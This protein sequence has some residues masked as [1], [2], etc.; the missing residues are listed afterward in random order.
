VQ[1]VEGIAP[2]GGPLDMP[3]LPG[4]DRGLVA[5]MRDLPGHPAGGEL[6]A[7]F[8]RVVPGVEVDPDV[9]GQRAQV[10]EFVQRRGQQRGVVPTRRGQH[11]VQQDAVAVHHATDS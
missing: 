5:F 9:I 4:L 11:A 1:L 8:L 10:I 3:P 2:G 7:G 6:I